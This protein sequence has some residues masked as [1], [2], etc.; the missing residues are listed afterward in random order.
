MAREHHF[1]D[2]VQIQRTRRKKNKGAN[3]EEVTSPVGALIP[4]LYRTLTGKESRD[5]PR[6][7]LPETSQLVI[8]VRD[9]DG[10]DVTLKQGDEL[11]LFYRTNGSLVEKP[12]RLKITGDII[13]TRR[14]GYGEIVT[15]HFEV[16]EWTEH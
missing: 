11:D 12:V 9:D 10:D 3:A 16:V 13:P 8:L 15:Y 6:T 7:S 1:R 2:R 5:E 4:C 14:G